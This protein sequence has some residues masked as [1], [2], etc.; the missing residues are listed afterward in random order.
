[1]MEEPM[2]VDVGVDAQATAKLTLVHQRVFLSVSLS[3]RTLAGHVELEYTADDGPSPKGAHV[4][5]AA[6]SGEGATAGG[7]ASQMLPL[8]RTIALHCFRCRLREV[9]V[10][11][12]RVRDFILGDPFA[13]PLAP[14]R[15]FHFDAAV[16][17]CEDPELRI[18]IPDGAG[19][20]RDAEGMRRLTVRIE[21]TVKEP[22]GGVHFALPSH[23]TY[24]DRP[25]HAFADIGVGGPRQW[26]PCV[27]N[28]RE[29]CRW[30]IELS[31][32]AEYMVIA[33][34]ILEQQLRV[35]K[36]DRRVFRF[37]VH[38]PASALE[39]GFAVGKFDV[40]CDPDVPHVTYF[41]PSGM[42][43]E[44]T[45]STESFSY[46]V[47]ECCRYLGVQSHG[48]RQQFHHQHHHQHQRAQSRQGK[49]DSPGNP[50][51]PF[52][53]YS[54]VFVDNCMAPFA[55]FAG[56]A[57]LHVRLLHSRRVLDQTRESRATF[58]RAL[59][60][61]WF[62]HVVVPASAAD[63]WIVGGIA[64][65]VAEVV[66]RLPRMLGDNEVRHEMGEW[67][68]DAARRMHDKGEERYVGRADEC[69]HPFVSLAIPDE[70]SKPATAEEG[71]VARRMR[72]PIAMSAVARAIGAE[73]I[74][75]IV[76]GLLDGSGADD[77][78]KSD[79]GHKS[80]RRRLV[81]IDVK[82]F[83]K[84]LRSVTGKDIVIQV[85]GW[86]DRL[87]VRMAFKFFEDGR[88]LT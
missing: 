84:K 82:R 19:A 3:R 17:A 78:K 47:T 5:R 4:S 27:E 77:S 49:A 54:V 18:P 71:A 58:V 62:G 36:G 88:K 6:L 32:A 16:R 39:I 46:A 11:G 74:K 59:T 23:R 33:G 30:T 29:R 9:Y 22:G 68:E 81:E 73:A 86:N 69:L 63:E 66:L 65:F 55:S 20:T 85:P 37:G 87:C 53:A 43:A 57:F 14:S 45:H 13:E 38:A 51:L 75:G 44:L 24:V 52:G 72:G 76:R 15:T 7:E 21:Y 26:M 56:G 25:P 28:R 2:E 80:D 83:E 1:M 61:Q 41:A 40:L 48:Q 50:A 60:C 35:V 8:P 34:G 12:I 70:K 64:S 10:D 79:K 42:L 67:I 31:V